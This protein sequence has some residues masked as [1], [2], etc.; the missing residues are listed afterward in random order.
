VLFVSDGYA[1]LH[2][3][4][5]L[6]GQCDLMTSEQTLPDLEMIRFFNQRAL[7]WTQYRDASVTFASIDRILSELKP[8]LIAPAH[9]GIVDAGHEDLLGL[10]KRGMRVGS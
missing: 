8:R 4:F 2:V 7:K 9:S 6:R 1:Y 5:H 10:I 3:P